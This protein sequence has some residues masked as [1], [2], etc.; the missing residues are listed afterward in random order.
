MIILYINSLIPLKMSFHF[1][2]FS[3]VKSKKRL[4]H[5]SPKTK[6]HCKI[7]PQVNHY[8]NSH[9]YFKFISFQQAFNHINSIIDNMFTSISKM[10]LNTHNNNIKHKKSFN[11]II[12][13]SS[14]FI[15]LNKINEIQ[16]KLNS[17]SLQMKTFTYKDDLDFSISTLETQTG[18]ECNSSF[19]FKDTQTPTFAFSNQKDNENYI[20][21]NQ[22]EFSLENSIISNSI[23]NEFECNNI[24][25]PQ[26][27][28]KALLSAVKEM[29]S[30]E[31]ITKEER[32]F[33]KEKII[34]KDEHFYTIMNN[35]DNLSQEDI[36]RNLRRFLKGF[37]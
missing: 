25:K 28:P 36:I 4:S 20:S 7:Q 14:M 15:L 26:L 23:N 22:N 10:N 32:E 12:T 37:K 30:K 18:T 29:K 11:L 35:S 8:H 5:L 6:S 9:N 31:I 24:N 34:T 3:P 16:N 13:S 17:L 19:D 21:L 33:L 27:K 2:N 1:Y